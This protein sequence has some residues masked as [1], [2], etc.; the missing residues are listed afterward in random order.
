[1]VI[2]L[3]NNWLVI[4]QLSIWLP[5]SEIISKTAKRDEVRCTK[6]HRCSQFSCSNTFRYLTP[7]FENLDPVF[8]RRF[9]YENLRRV[10]QKVR[11]LYKGNQLGIQQCKTLDMPSASSHLPGHFT[12]D[13]RE[14]R[15]STWD[16]QSSA[17]WHIRKNRAELT[18]S[19]GCPK[20]LVPAKHFTDHCKLMARACAWEIGET[21]SVPFSCMGITPM[22]F[23]LPEGTRTTM[24]VCA[25][26]GIIEVWCTAHSWP[27]A[28]AQIRNL[29]VKCPAANKGTIIILSCR[30]P[31]HLAKQTDLH[32]PWIKIPWTLS[33]E[34]CWLA[35]VLPRSLCHVF[36]PPVLTWAEWIGALLW[37]VAR[38]SLGGSAGLSASLEILETLG[39][40]VG[41][42]LF[43]L[44]KLNEVE[45]KLSKELAAKQGGG[46]WIF[47]VSV[48]N[49]ST[50][51][52]TYLHHTSVLSHK[53]LKSCFVPLKPLLPSKVS[54]HY[55][56]RW[57]C[58]VIRAE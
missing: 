29:G 47:K 11:D 38:H 30:L 6:W 14:A 58:R 16:W 43:V 54:Q 15:L 5:D 39:L 50:K 1:M 44:K 40:E 13:C 25:G 49:V 48:G 24:L 31:V 34:V 4:T 42:Q 57:H 21:G 55:C 10:R 19:L 3:R 35:S 28:L 33:R 18:I 36:L 12:R 22:A 8:F 45:R 2:C 41:T 27:K 53:P 51:K 46:K 9:S 20:V 26:P 7:A 17:F 23:T 56:E 37:W 52:E 32:P